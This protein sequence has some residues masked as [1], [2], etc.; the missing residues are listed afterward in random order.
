MTT[1]G[2]FNHTLSEFLGD[3]SATFPEKQ[4]IVFYDQMLPQLLKANERAGLEFFMNAARDHGDAILAKDNSLFDQPICIGKGL[5]LANL[6]NDNGLDDS[7][8]NAIWNYLNTLFVLGMTLEG[9]GSDILT[10]IESLAKSTAEKLKCGD[11]TLETVLPNIMSSVGDMMGVG[12]PQDDAPDFNALLS[13]VMA[14]M[15]G[16]VPQKKLDQ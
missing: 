1:I 3:L 2:A 8:R 12:I 10:G 7:S 11:E 14:S 4:D 6:W 13:S 16:G 15:G 9:V 5:D